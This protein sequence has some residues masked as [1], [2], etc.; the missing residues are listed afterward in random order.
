MRLRAAEVG[1]MALLTAQP[2]MIDR[3]LWVY[4][5]NSYTPFVGDDCLRISHLNTLGFQGD[6]DVKLII[7]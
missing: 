6:L 1:E 7:N 4:M 2:F 3:L 5:Y